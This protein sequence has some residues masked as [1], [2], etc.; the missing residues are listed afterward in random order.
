MSE[1]ELSSWK[2]VRMQQKMESTMKINIEFKRYI[3]NKFHKL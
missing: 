2:N 3:D 1:N